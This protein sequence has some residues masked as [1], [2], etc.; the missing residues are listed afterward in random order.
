MTSVLARQSSGHDPSIGHA[1]PVNRP[2]RLQSPVAARLTYARGPSDSTEMFYRVR[3]LKE[4]EERSNIED[5]NLETRIQDMRT[6][7]QPFTLDEN[8]FQLERLAVPD[9]IDW[10]SDDEVNRQY[11]H[12]CADVGLE[13]PDFEQC[14]STRAAHIISCA[15]GAQAVLSLAGGGHQADDWS[16]EGFCLRPHSQTWTDHVS[17]LAFWI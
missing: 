12:W 10:S 2:A 17:C 4:G 9:D 3:Q 8:G 1:F 13:D 11:L 14:K 5:F 15:T 7:E 16:L 6:I